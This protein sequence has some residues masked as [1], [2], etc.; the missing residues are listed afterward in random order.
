MF[1][2]DKVILSAG[3]MALTHLLF[4]TRWSTPSFNAW[5]NEFSAPRFARQDFA[6][7]A[8]GYMLSLAAT[9]L[10]YYAFIRFGIE[11][12]L[13]LLPIAIVGNLVTTIHTRRL[14]QKTRE[15]SEASRVHLATVEALATAIDARDQVGIGHVRRTQIYAIGLGELLGLS[16]ED[17]DA[18]RTG[19]LLHD[20]GKAG[21]TGP[22][23]EQAGQ[24]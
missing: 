4:I 20:I 18:L 2:A 1:I 23:F 9:I 5:A 21:G 3:A 19:A 16:E 22:H 12:G 15:I 6:G 8:L 7:K 24:A 14:A 17:I 10:L 13:V 11:F